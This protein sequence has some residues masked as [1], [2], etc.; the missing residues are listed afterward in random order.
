MDASS[1]SQ[2]RVLVVD[3]DQDIREALCLLLMDAGYATSVASSLAEALEQIETTTF[4]LIVTDAFAHRPSDALASI[5]TLQRAAHPTPVGIVSGW[6]P[7]SDDAQQ[8]GLAFCLAKPFDL[9]QL[10]AQIAATLQTPLNQDQSR[11]VPVI[12]RYF[13]ALTARDWDALVDLCTENVTYVLPGN[14]PFSTTITGK[15]A[16]RAYTEETF[17]HFPAASFDDV[18]VYASPTGLAAHYRGCWHMPDGSEARM[19]GAVHFQFEDMRIQQ[20]GV[21]LNDERLRALLQA[22]QNR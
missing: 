13:A 22:Q 9:D 12:H 19:T 8:A 17:S 3:D 4:R 6:S 21:R 7:T 11:Q 15:A 20:I 2:L 1:A 5:Q 10:L 14:T 18:V 16:F